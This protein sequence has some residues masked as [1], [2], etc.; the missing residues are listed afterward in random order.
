M[1]ELRPIAVLDF[2]DI[3]PGGADMARPVFVEVAPSD[4]LVDESYQR[5]LSRRSL[6]VIRR[7]V[8]RWDWRSFH[9]PIVVRSESGAFHIIDGQHTA[10][11]AACH[12]DIKT[13]PVQVVEAPEIAQRATAFVSVNTNRVSVT[14]M[15][16]HYAEL[17]A[18]DDD[19]VT[20][21]Q[22]CD[23]TGVRLLRMPPNNGAYAVGDC[24]ALGSIRSLISK[25][26]PHG[27]RRV[28]KLLVEAKAAPITAGLIKAIEA[29]LFEPEYAGMVTDEAIGTTIRGEGQ[30]QLEREARAFAQTHGLSAWRGL[31]GVIFRHTPK[32]RD[33][34]RIAAA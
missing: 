11:A 20:L 27:A 10:I 22:V 2:P 34:R 9:P 5:S 19:A 31:A 26:H 17:A 18:G 29:L 28:L 3:A 12:P 30:V 14:P 16:I 7:A 24:Y 25:R 21:A 6:S 13:I 32:V 1:S 23:R 15:Q 33:G 4:L 8:A